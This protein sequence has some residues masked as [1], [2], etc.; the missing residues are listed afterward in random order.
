M[1]TQKQLPPENALVRSTVR[2]LTG[3]QAAPPTGVGTGFFYKVTN[4]S[5]N[6]VKIFIVTNKHVV[7][8]AEVV[9][10]VLPYAKSLNEE[11][12]SWQPKGRVDSPIVLP[13]SGNVISHPSEEID[14]CAI[15]ITKFVGVVLNSGH[16]LRCMIIDSTWLPKEEDIELVRDIEQVLVIGYP[17]GLWDDHNNMPIARVG[18]SATHPLA[19]YKNQANFLIDVSAFPGSSGSPVFTYEAPLF[20]TS[21]G[22]S[23]PGTKIQFI[24]VVWGVIEHDVKGEMKQI[25]IPSSLSPAVPVIKSSLN[26][27]IALHGK[28][29]R[30]LDSLIFDGL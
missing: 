3:E 15:D 20:R 21:S 29:I 16:Q 13:L 9:H 12:S 22:G 1:K 30:D 17:T 14:L 10:F 27:A 28:K 23:T 19:L 26:L 11:E 5:T 24:G 6:V 4:P 8:G 2:L 18:T 7:R 25:E